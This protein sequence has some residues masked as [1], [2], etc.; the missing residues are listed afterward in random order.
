MPEMHLRWALQPHAPK[1]KRLLF[2]PSC[3]QAEASFHTL[4]WCLHNTSWVEQFPV[5]GTPARWL[6]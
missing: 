3:S 2:I 1:S 4:G 6:P 5:R